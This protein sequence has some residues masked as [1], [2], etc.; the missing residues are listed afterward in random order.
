MAERQAVFQASLRRCL[1][2]EGF[3]KRFYEVFLDSSPEVRAKFEGTDFARQ[4]RA[5]RDS[6]F[7]ME[8]IAESEPEGP[9]WKALKELAVVHDRQHRDIRPEL[10]DLWLDSL[11]KTVSEHDPEYGPEIDSAWRVALRDGIEYMRSAWE[12]S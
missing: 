7:V 1:E 12:R 6:F 5:L 8:V 9:A 4:R 10:Y 11:M 2:S 3:L